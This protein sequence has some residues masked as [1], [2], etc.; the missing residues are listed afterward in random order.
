VALL[1][2]AKP[3]RLFVWHELPLQVDVPLGPKMV[4]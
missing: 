3:L 2:Q 4:L 1:P